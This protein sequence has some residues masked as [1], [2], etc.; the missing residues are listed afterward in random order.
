MASLWDFSRDQFVG[1]LSALEFILI[2]RE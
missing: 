1:V 2:V